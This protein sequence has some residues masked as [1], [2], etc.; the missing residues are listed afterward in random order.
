MRSARLTRPSPSS[1]VRRPRTRKWR[2]AQRRWPAA[3]PNVVSVVAR[4]WL[5]SRTTARSSS[6]RSSPPTISAR[7]PCRSTGG[8]RAPEVRYILEHSGSPRSGMRRGTRRPRSRSDEGHRSHVGACRCL[9]SSLGRMDNARCPAHDFHEGRPRR[10][11]GRRRSPPHVHVGHNGAPEG[12]HDHP[13][14]T[15]RGR[16]SRTS[17]SSGSRGRISDSP[18]VPCTTSARSISPRPL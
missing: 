13:R 1:T 15:S 6:R 18:A 14:R 8:S 9:A 12:R 7:L 5:S 17:L 3:C 4:S 11:R 2:G 10:S 16:T